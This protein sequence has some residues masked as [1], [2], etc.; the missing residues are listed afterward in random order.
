[1]ST[2][3]NKVNNWNVKITNNEDEFPSNKSCLVIVYKL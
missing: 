3:N 1:M 2:L